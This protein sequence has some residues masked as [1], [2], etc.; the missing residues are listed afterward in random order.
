MVLWRQFPKVPLVGVYPSLG[1]RGNLVFRLPPYNP[2]GEWMA[3]I[4]CNPS[5]FAFLFSVPIFLRISIGLAWELHSE[6]LWEGWMIGRQARPCMNLLGMYRWFSV[7]PQGFVVLFLVVLGGDFRSPLLVVFSVCFRDLA[8]G[9][10]MGKIHV[11][12]LWFFCLWFPSQIHKLRG[13]I[14]GFSV[15]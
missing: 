2:S 5:S 11:N 3:A 15:F 13:S 8:L 14:L 12:P 1:L 9:N 6:I 10:L 4:S 7:V